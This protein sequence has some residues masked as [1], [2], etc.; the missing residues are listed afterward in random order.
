M[1]VTVFTVC[2]SK[3]GFVHLCLPRRLSW[4]TCSLCGGIRDVSELVGK[5]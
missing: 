1:E 5:Q 4:L 3:F 2:A